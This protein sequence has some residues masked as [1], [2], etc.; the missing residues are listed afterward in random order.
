MLM[1]V[2]VD[3]PT[4]LNASRILGGDGWEK[5]QS[6]LQKLKSG[7]DLSTSMEQAFSHWTDLGK[8]AGMS[9]TESC[10]ITCG[11][12]AMILRES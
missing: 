5:Q 4:Y 3:L 6:E 7:K 9:P 10:P 11:D 1:T 8:E 12:Q 2:A